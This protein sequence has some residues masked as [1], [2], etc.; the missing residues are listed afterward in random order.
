MLTQSPPSALRRLAGAAP[1]SANAARPG[2]AAPPA[3]ERALA[4]ALLRVAAEVPALGLSVMGR[5]TRGATGEAGFEGLPPLA[6]CLPIDPPCAA[7]GLRPAPDALAAASGVLVF[8]PSLVDALIEVQTIAR[9]DGAP[10]PARRPTRIDAALAQPFAQAVLD[11]L[12]D[13]LP[14]D[15]HGPEPGA[16][17]RGSFLAGTDGL[18]LN[19][20]A[21]RWA[22]VRLDLL[23]A[24]GARPASLALLLPDPDLGEPA[25]EEAGVDRPDP[26]WARRVDGTMRGA[27]VRLDAVLPPLRLTLADMVAL[28]P[29]T[30]LPLEGAP[31]ASLRLIAGASGRGRP[32]RARMPWGLTMEGRLGRLGGSRAVRLSALPGDPAGGAAPPGLAAPE[33]TGDAPAES[34]ETADRPDETPQ[35]AQATDFPDLPDLPDVP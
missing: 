32:A 14:R 19:F 1:A 2:P 29:G 26:D 20:T 34:P 27:Q 28:A 13:A 21:P 12:S 5:E 22:R 3:L 4:T 16:L 10:R 23:L 30:L 17:R 11:A 25:T 8:D 33:G 18:G 15:Y 31:L 9:V 6:L 24:D 35:L 7:D